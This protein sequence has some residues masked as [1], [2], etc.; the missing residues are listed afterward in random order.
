MDWEQMYNRSVEDHQQTLRDL[1]VC[2]QR[3]A[4][5]KLYAWRSVGGSIWLHK[6]SEDDAPLYTVEESV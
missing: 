6:T 5:F 4:S 3:L 2:E 1:Q